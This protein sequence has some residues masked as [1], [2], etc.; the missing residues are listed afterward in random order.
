[1][2]YYIQLCLVYLHVYTSITIFCARPLRT[3]TSAL[4]TILSPAPRRVPNQEDPHRMFVDYSAR[5]DCL[6]SH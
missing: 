6:D 5:A 3:E 2:V 4:F 1:M